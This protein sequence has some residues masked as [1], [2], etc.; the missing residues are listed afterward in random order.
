MLQWVQTFLDYLRVEKRYSVHTLTAYETDLK[1]FFGFTRKTYN[2]DDPM[3]INH[4]MVRSWM[5]ALHEAGI[6][7]VSIS[8][9]LS[10]LKALFTFLIRRNVLEHNPMRKVIAPKSAKKLP[11]VVQQAE[12]ERIFAAFGTS[13]DFGHCRDKLVLELLYGL[14]LRRSE[15]ISLRLT[16][17]NFSKNEVLVRGKGAKQRIIP[18]GNGLSDAVQEYLRWREKKFPDVEEPR[19]LLTDKGG[20]LY[21]GWVYNRVKQYLSAKSPHVLRHTFATHLSENGADLNAIKALLG[22]S[23]LAATQVYM[24][25]SVEHLKAVYKN[26]HPQ[27]LDEDENSGE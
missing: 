11:V 10:S 18:M 9:K 27:A 20:A 24:H 21:P 16:D 14:G 8:R 17:I 15:L 12:L 7:P 25:N 2:T 5:V 23:S 1:Q 13:H 26:A 3:A 19:L 4:Q 22:H 6:A